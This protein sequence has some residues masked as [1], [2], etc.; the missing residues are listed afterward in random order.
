MRPDN[1]RMAAFA[2]FSRVWSQAK[3]EEFDREAEDLRQIDLRDCQRHR[4]LVG[5]KQR[6]AGDAFLLPS[7]R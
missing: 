4:D 6:D 5:T 2:E 1:D 7:K 3:A